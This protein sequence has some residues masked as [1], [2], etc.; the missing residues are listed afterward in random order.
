MPDFSADLNKMASSARAWE[1]ASSDLKQ[2]AGKAQGIQ[3][4]NKE[5]V[6]GLFQ[7]VWDA[8]VSAAQYMSARLSEG[9]RQ[10]ESMGNSIEHVAKVLMEQDANFAGVL[11][12]L[13]EE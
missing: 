10:T 2:G 4:S 9:S 11:L 12:R 3:Y 1:N 13:D 8:Q 5:V 7:E 6:W